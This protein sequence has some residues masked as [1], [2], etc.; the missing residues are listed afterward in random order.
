MSNKVFYKDKLM[1]IIENH[2]IELKT[3]KQG[4]STIF[5]DISESLLKKGKKI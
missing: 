5:H 1:E 3:N 4:C 2:L